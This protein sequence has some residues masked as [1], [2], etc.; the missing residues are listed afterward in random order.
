MHRPLRVLVGHTQ[1]LLAEGLRLVVAV[2]EVRRNNVRHHIGASEEFRQLTG[3]LFVLIVLGKV[4][5]VVG[6]IDRLV[7]KISLFG[8]SGAH[9]S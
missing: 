7:V 9:A 3:L 8:E 2:G 6:W 5:T 4:W 1:N